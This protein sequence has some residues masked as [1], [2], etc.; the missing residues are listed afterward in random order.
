[1]KSFFELISDLDFEGMIVE[2]SFENQS[3]VRLNYDRGIDRIEM[4]MD[5]RNVDVNGL[6]FPLD[7]FFFALKKA[8]KLLVKCYREDQLKNNSRERF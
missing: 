3:V 5:L 4:E 8:K 1:M 6:I 7:D 2:I